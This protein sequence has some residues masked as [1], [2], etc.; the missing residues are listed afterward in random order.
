MSRYIFD[1]RSFTETYKGIEFDLT[2]YFEDEDLPLEDTFDD[3]IDNISKLYKKIDNCE[4][5]YFC[6][7]MQASYNDIELSNDY[8]GA[9]LYESYD[10]FINEDGYFAD[11]KSNVLTEGYNELKQLKSQFDTLKFEDDTP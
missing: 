9:C 3:D 5:Y 4:L 6:A 2:I 1:Q 8:L 7:H 11:M 10:A